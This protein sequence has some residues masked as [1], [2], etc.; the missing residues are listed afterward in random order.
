MKRSL[1]FYMIVVCLFGSCNESDTA[2]ITAID[3]EIPMRVK[4]IV[5]KN[6]SWGDYELKFT[7]KEDG[8]LQEVVR[9]GTADDIQ[10]RNIQGIFS[11]EYDLNYFHFTVKDR[12]L[13]IDSDSSCQISISLS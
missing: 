4:R 7:Y 11:V 8:R 1:L 12:V 9:Y 13:N 10:K 6:A 3:S 2:Y 5:G